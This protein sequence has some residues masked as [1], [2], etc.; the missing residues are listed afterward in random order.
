MSVLFQNRIPNELMLHF[1]LL[2][3][4]LRILYDPT[5]CLRNNPLAKELLI[6]YVNLMKQYFGKIHIIFN[7]HNLL[8]LS[9][10]I[11]RFGPLD[12]FSVIS[13]ENHL[14]TT[15]QLVRKGFQPLT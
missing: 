5:Q 7:V 1:N 4:A 8:H 15:K 2:N 10:D 13:F 12:S 11:L 6:I 14:Q 3:C 9:D